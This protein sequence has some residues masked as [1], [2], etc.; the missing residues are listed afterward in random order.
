MDQKN[1]P[2]LI[3][4]LQ[5]AIACCRSNASFAHVPAFART[6]LKEAA[7]NVEFFLRRHE[8]HRAFEE[9]RLATGVNS[10]VVRFI[11]ASA[12]ATTALHEELEG[13]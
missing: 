1:L 12:E 13:A 5:Q 6:R 3:D 9:A 4:F 11:Q 7:D 10:A 8:Y 2:Q